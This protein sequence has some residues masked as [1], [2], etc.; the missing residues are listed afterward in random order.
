MFPLNLNGFIRW[1]IMKGLFLSIIHSFM[2]KEEVAVYEWWLQLLQYQ[3][4][5]EN[6]LNHLTKTN[7]VCFALII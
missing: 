4:K 7:V 6:V 3:G 1:T 5:N 2:P